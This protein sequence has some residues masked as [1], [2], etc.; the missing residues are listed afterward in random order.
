MVQLTNEFSKII[1]LINHESSRKLKL[2]HSIPLERAKKLLLLW[3]FYVLN[4]LCD[5]TLSFFFEKYLKYLQIFLTERSSS[6]SCVFVIYRN[7]GFWF[8]QSYENF[9]CGSI[10]FDFII[11]ISK[12]WLLWV[13]WTSVEFSVDDYCCK[14]NSIL[15]RK[16]KKKYPRVLFNVNCSPSNDSKLNLDCFHSRTL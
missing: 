4:D 13:A 9:N 12:F 7:L 2:S 16:A 10:C 15:F 6:F 3:L 11:K 14:Y 5:K 1:F 8:E